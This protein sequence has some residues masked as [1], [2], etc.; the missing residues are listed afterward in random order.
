[1]L[2][3]AA[4]WYKMAVPIFPSV[5]LQSC[6]S[7]YAL[8]THWAVH[9]A[10][11]TFLALLRPDRYA[12]LLDFELL[13]PWRY[14]RSVVPTGLADKCL[15]GVVWDQVCCALTFKLTHVHYKQKMDIAF[16]ACFLHLPAWHSSIT[17]HVVRLGHC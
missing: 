10:A 16:T 1:M 3:L 15:V 12:E 14:S 6:C 2:L 13:T 7:C 5:L 11:V 9:R 4:V 17:V 8:W